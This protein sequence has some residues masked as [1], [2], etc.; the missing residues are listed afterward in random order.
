M[1]TL[2]PLIFLNT[3]PIQYFAPLYRYLAESGLPIQ[4]MYCNDKTVKG[5]IDK[6]F[7]QQVKWDI[8]LLEGYSSQFFK[9]YGWGKRG[10]F[11]CI[12]PGMISFLKKQPPSTVVLHSWNYASDILVL[13]GAKLYG[14]QLAFRGESNLAQ[15]R[16]KSKLNQLIKRPILK[17]LFFF[18][19]QFFYIGAQNKAFYQSFGIDGKRL[20]PSPYA[21]DNERFQKAAEA[22]SKETAREK[23]KI[24]SDAFVVLYSGKYI[25]KKRPLDLL[26]AAKKASASHL[27][28]VMMG[29][30]KLRADMEGYISQ[31]GLE[32]KV[33]LTGFV[34]QSEIPELYAAADLFVMCSD[35]GETWGLSA[36]EAMN[37]KLPLLLS[38]LTGCSADLVRQGENGYVFHTGDIRTLTSYIDSFAQMPA[39]QLQQMGEKSME[40]VGNFSFQ[41]ILEGFLTA[42]SRSQVRP[43][44]TENLL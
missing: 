39:G 17:L 29:E 9:N 24:P 15:E 34:N 7:G 30:G 35:T 43:V 38:H 2:R 19:R 18:V 8:P 3:H 40:I 4:V 14:H 33:R 32:E 22:I 44:E 1:T 21:V 28:F 27:F 13:I 5:G 31:H 42:G 36:N 6:E 10:F 25:Q 16:L 12:N 26:R 11:S 37:A 41:K 23:W 20:I